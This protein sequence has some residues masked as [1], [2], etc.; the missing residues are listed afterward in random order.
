M[1]LEQRAALAEQPDDHLGRPQLGSAA[2]SPLGPLDV[3]DDR[4]RPQ[5]RDDA[6]EVIEI[7][8]LDVEDDLVQVRRPGAEAQVGDVAAL[9][10]DRRATASRDCPAG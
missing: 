7:V 9:A 6:A 1:A 4:K 8:D 2:R 5:A 10:A 3:G